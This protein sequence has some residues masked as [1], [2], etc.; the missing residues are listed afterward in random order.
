[1]LFH[2]PVDIPTKIADT[3]EHAIIIF[4]RWLSFIPGTR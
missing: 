3:I 4:K 2:R 1:M